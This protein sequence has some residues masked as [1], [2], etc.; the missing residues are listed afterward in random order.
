MPAGESSKET[1][2]RALSGKREGGMPGLDVFSAGIPYMEAFGRR[3]SRCGRA[4]PM[5]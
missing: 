5:I 4:G 2:I 3:L 1:D